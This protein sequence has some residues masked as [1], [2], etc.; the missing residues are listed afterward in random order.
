[1]S[2]LNIPIYSLTD[3]YIPFT[4]N[5]KDRLQ[6]N[7]DFTHFETKNDVKIRTLFEEY[8]SDIISNLP[9]PPRPLE[10]PHTYQPPP[11]GLPEDLMMERIIPEP[12]DIWP[13]KGRTPNDPYLM[14]G[15]YFFPH[16]HVPR[17]LFLINPYAALQAAVVWINQRIYSENNLELLKARIAITPI[18]FFKHFETFWTITCQFWSE[19]CP[20]KVHTYLGTHFT[21]SVILS[22]IENINLNSKT[23]EI[24][25]IINMAFDNLAKSTGLTLDFRGDKNTYTVPKPPRSGQITQTST[26]RGCWCIFCSQGFNTQAELRNHMV[27]EC[28]QTKFTIDDE[29]NIE[30]SFHCPNCMPTD[31]YVNYEQIVYHTFYFCTINYRSKCTYCGHKKSYCECARHRESIKDTLECMIAET[32]D[33]TANLLNR[34]NLLILSTFLEYD[35]LE[36]LEVLDSFLAQNNKV[37]PEEETSVQVSIIDMDIKL[38]IQSNEDKT[39]SIYVKYTNTDVKYEKLE[40]IDTYITQKND[41]YKDLPRAFEQLGL[42]TEVTL[43]WRAPHYLDSVC[44]ICFLDTEGDP[45]HSEIQHPRC[46][47][48]TTQ[49]IDQEE[50]IKHTNNH[51]ANVRCPQKSCR[52]MLRTF[53]DL[54]VHCD[55]HP[56]IA[57][58]DRAPCSPEETL[59]WREC[60]MSTGNPLQSLKH[61]GIFHLK[62]KQDYSTFIEWFKRTTN[63]NWGES[64]YDLP[65]SITQ[66]QQQVTFNTPSNMMT[67]HS[68]SQK[69]AQ[70]NNS[71]HPNPNQPT[72]NSPSGNGNN[73]SGNNGGN[74]NDSGGKEMT[75]IQRMK[76]NMANSQSFPCENKKCKEKNLV[77]HVK[78]ELD[79][80][81]KNCHSCPKEF[82]Q[83]S[84]MF[85]DILLKHILQHKTVNSEEYSCS[86]C[87]ALFADLDQLE[88]HVAANHNLKCYVCKKT[89]FTSRTSLKKHTEQ[90]TSASL[91]INDS[92]KDRGN[93][94]MFY[95]LEW[96][97]KTK[98]GTSDTNELQKIKAMAIKN[99]QLSATPELYLKKT[100]PFFTVPHF[101][102]NE[103]QKTIPATRLTALPKFKPNNKKLNNYIQMYGV[104]N[105]LIFIK[106]E[107]KTTEKSFCSQLIHQTDENARNQIRS[108]IHG[109][110]YNAN[111]EDL[112]ATYQSLYYELNLRQIHAQ[113]MYLSRETAESHMDFFG[114]IKTIT[115]LAS[116]YLKDEEQ[117]AFELKNLRDNFLRSTG[118][119]FTSMIEKREASNGMKYTPYELMVT[120]NL[121]EETEKRSEDYAIRS[122]STKKPKAKYSQKK[123]PLHSLII[124]TEPTKRYPNSKMK[125]IYSK[126][127]REKPQ[128]ELSFT[129]DHVDRKNYSRQNQNNGVNKKKV[130]NINGK[131][132]HKKNYQKYP[133]KPGLDTTVKPKVNV[134]EDS[135][136]KL[137]ALG[138]PTDGS[139]TV[140]FLC[141][142]VGNHFPG[143][144]RLYKNIPVSETK[145]QK[146]GFYHH[147]SECKNTPSPN[148]GKIIRN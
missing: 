18:T 145:C 109:E 134:S 79:I 102:E 34:K 49:F 131:T 10:L 80:H 2:Q 85:E 129:R 114:R 98:L 41:N 76:S 38:F 8:K 74:H 115:N 101:N 22:G 110:L 32:I 44:S 31:M 119:K 71:T 90:C 29:L 62:S 69:Q 143:G 136:I 37:F 36:R 144:C 13:Q 128:R 88:T 122:F 137:K 51:V 81:V 127:R 111:L 59:N 46:W 75:Q 17:Y 113:S 56:E 60:T 5:D 121:Q 93:Q 77:F 55:T 124:D 86:F 142:I 96:L 72:S 16:M 30:P 43:D 26:F 87:G 40:E 65:S 67:T 120:F 125:K 57:I 47:C 20:Q 6:S 104:F 19:G 53:M 141:G 95:L 1:M 94:P 148:T 97:S 58:L 84:S 106:N 126:S 25:D 48:S 118:E 100:K 15:M 35:K 9:E 83:F 82:C 140:C 11:I 12:I 112:L 68:S 52:T 50:M 24:S 138:F 21:E 139:I 103:T 33:T 117:K 3:Q 130:R 107:Y 28:L 63:P 7:S 133:N 45:S 73:H 42:E 39:I 23:G 116:F 14:S 54:L 66:T 64:I 61:T 123:N 105:E 4:Q 147:H 146:C 89:D 132:E 99:Q 91:H 108:M 92:E 27:E 135:K 70:G 78:E